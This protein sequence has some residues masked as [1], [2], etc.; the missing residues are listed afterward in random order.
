MS[1]VFSM[2][3]DG[4]PYINSLCVPFLPSKTRA[5]VLRR[6]GGACIVYLSISLI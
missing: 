2:K 4:E 6:G 3:Y 1:T 5:D